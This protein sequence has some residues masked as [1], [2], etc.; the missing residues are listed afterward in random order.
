MAASI[1]QKGTSELE[2]GTGIGAF[3]IQEHLPKG[4]GGMAPVYMARVRQH[5]RRC[6]VLARTSAP[7]PSETD[8]PAT[9]NP[10]VAG[11]PSRT[12][13]GL[14]RPATPSAALSSVSASRP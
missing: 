12:H 14:P 4:K 10:T 7:S 11:W 3:L 9:T 2:T 6:G 13:I 5:Y 8:V 1:E